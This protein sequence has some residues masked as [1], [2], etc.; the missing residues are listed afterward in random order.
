[1]EKRK[2]NLTKQEPTIHDIPVSYSGE[3][4]HV[5]DRISYSEKE[6][7][8]TEMAERLIITHDDSCVYE[9]SEY[10]KVMKV[11]IAKYYTDIDTSD[12]D[13]YDIVDFI[14]TETWNNIVEV[15]GVDLS[16]VLGIYDRLVDAV[17][18]TYAD[19]RGLT[20]AIRKSFGFLFTGEDI[21]DT[22]AKAE[23][24][25]GTMLDA[26][27]ALQKRQETVDNGKLNVGGNVI[28]FAKKGK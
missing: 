25:K 13:E 23:T 16:V 3:L 15:L 8:A 4:I 10:D 7:M 6:A 24:V 26:L 28:S 27:S 19:D 22:L 20:K 21:T 12:A 11:M 17:M 9:S 18:V 1:M 2:Y 14:D 5:V